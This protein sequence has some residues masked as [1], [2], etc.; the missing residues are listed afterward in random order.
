MQG[1][2]SAGSTELGCLSSLVHTKIRR[3]VTGS[4]QQ[5]VHHLEGPSN[6]LSFMHHGFQTDTSM[7]DIVVGARTRDSIFDCFSFFFRLLLASLATRARFRPNFALQT[8]RSTN[9]TISTRVASTAGQGSLCNGVM[10]QVK[11]YNIGH[12]FGEIAL[13][14]GEPRK[15]CLQSPVGMNG[16]CLHALSGECLRQRTCDLPC[17]HKASVRQS[18]DLSFRSATKSF[19]CSHLRM[20]NRCWVLSETS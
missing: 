1:H 9:S 18:P 4:R 14:L 12:F 13:L 7:H 2:N 19:L 10:R 17:N 6:V 3:H 11:T 5:H 15:A 8:R 16:E 20:C